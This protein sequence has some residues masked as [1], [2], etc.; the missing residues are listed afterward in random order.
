METTASVPF[1][2][3]SSILGDSATATASG[4]DPADNDDRSDVSS[5]LR[6]SE[7]CE[8]IDATVAAASEDSAVDSF[9][10]RDHTIEPT[11]LS[12]RPGRRITSSGTTAATER[13][14][15]TIHTKALTH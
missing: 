11:A 8:R 15:S 6:T 14:T 9:A 5:W 4:V 1:G 10:S 12:G 2:S 7:S 13:I 3:G